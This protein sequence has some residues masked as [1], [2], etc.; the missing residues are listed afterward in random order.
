M[1]GAVKVKRS[2]MLAGQ[3]LKLAQ[4]MHVDSFFA[5]EVVMGPKCDASASSDDALSCAGKDATPGAIAKSDAGEKVDESAN[6]CISRCTRLGI[7]PELGL[8][9]GQELDC[10]RL[11]PTNLSTT[12]CVIRRL[13]L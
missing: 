1:Q 12:R 7:T 13:N 6:A 4:W 8:H 3:G 10:S 5:S 11:G 2:F 9:F